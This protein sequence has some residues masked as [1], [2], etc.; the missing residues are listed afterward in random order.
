MMSYLSWFPTPNINDFHDSH[1]EK[2]LYG[3]GKPLI[4]VTI[5]AYELSRLVTYSIR[6]LEKVLGTSGY[7]YEIVV[8]DE[9]SPNDTYTQAPKASKNPTVRAYRLPRNMEAGAQFNLLVNRII[10]VKP[11]G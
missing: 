9:G 4:K 1:C 8:I 5:S 11:G 6:A 10:F 7:S 3:S 2:G